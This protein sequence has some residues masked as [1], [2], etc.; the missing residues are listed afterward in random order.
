MT[1][2]TGDDTTTN[3]NKIVF[4]ISES[5]ASPNVRR[6][7]GTHLLFFD[8]ASLLQKAVRRRSIRES[9]FAAAILLRDKCQK[10]LINRL[11]LFTV[12]DTNIILEP[13]LRKNMVNLAGSVNDEKVDWDHV[14]E[15]MSA[16]VFEMVFLVTNSEKS[17]VCDN[18]AHSAPIYAKSVIEHTNDSESEMI[19]NVREFIQWEDWKSVIGL[20]Y[21]MKKYF[22]VETCWKVFPHGRMKR[23][24]DIHSW[25][26]ICEQVAMLCWKPE[27]NR[28]PY[29]LNKSAAK[30]LWSELMTSKRDYNLRHYIDWELWVDVVLDKHTA[31]GKGKDTTWSLINHISEKDRDPCN[32]TDNRWSMNSLPDGKGKSRG[33]EH[34]FS[35]GAYLSPVIISD[36][37]L[38]DARKDKEEVLKQ[39]DMVKRDEPEVMDFFMKS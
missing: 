16:V 6:M 15:K 17:R 10:W 38:S 19:A 36:P 31:R 5:M 25:L 22:G 37:F 11:L 30:I 8:C 32:Q 14:S 39:L 34:F 33:I 4:C 27:G 24:R 26:E 7:I 29:Q 18:I 13:I 21:L 3:I 23:R 2:Q 28:L 1:V 35:R 9:M 12:E 20:L